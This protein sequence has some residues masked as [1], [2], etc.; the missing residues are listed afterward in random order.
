MLQIGL[1]IVLVGLVCSLI[2]IVLPCGTEIDIALSAMRKPSFHKVTLTGMNTSLIASQ[3]ATA[4]AI[5]QDGYEYEG[6]GGKYSW[7]GVKRSFQLPDGA[8]TDAA[9]APV[10]TPLS[11]PDIAAPTDQN[12]HSVISSGISSGTGIIADGSFLNPF[13][14]G[15][16]TY[17]ADYEYHHLTGYVIP[18]NGDAANWAA[19][20]STYGWAVS[21]TPK[22]HS[23]VVLHPGVQGAGWA[24]HVAV[25]EKVNPD[26]SVETTNWNV[27]G[28]GVFSWQTYYPG[29]GVSFV[30]HP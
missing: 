2:M 13:T 26:G 8:T 28:W 25:V 7:A 5:T 18:W 19:N 9:N 29:Q 24:G 20:A 30:W 12:D 6:A 16:C 3:G 11:A 14:P 1:T 27:I 15:Q 23:I 4:T 10:P 22:V 21:T 17:W